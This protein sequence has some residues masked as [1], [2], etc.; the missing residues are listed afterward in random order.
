MKSTLAG[1]FVAS[2]LALLPFVTTSHLFYGP[3]SAKFFFIVLLVDILA[4]I[5]AYRLFRDKATIPHGRW[6]S[7]SLIVLLLVQIAASLLGVFP[8]RSLWSDIFWSSGTFFIVHIGV[9][10][11]LL[12]NLLSGRD[13]SLVRRAVIFSAG[14]FAV[15]SIT[16]VAGFGA[17]GN[18]LWINLGQ[19]GLTLG[20]ETYAGTYLLLA[21]V[22][23]LLEVVSMKGGRKLRIALIGS[24]V[25][26]ALS[27]LMVNLDLFLGRS[28]FDEIIANPAHL[29]GLARASSAA[30]FAVLVFMAGYALT[31]RLVP[32]PS[33]RVVAIAWGGILIIASC[34]GIA[35]LF[36]PGS[37]VQQAY[38]EESSAA[39]II[40]WE[41]G[42]KAFAE[43]PFLGWG[44]ENFDRALM[45]HFDSRLFLEENLAEIWFDR[46]HNVFID[47]LVGSGAIGL[48]S[49]CLLSGAYFFVVYRARRRS[50]IGDTEMALLI[51][52]VPA[53]ILQ[54]QTGFDTIASYTLLAV[55][56]GYVLW[57]ERELTP[58]TF[59]LKQAPRTIVVW[60]FVIG[61]STSAFLVF[62]E[63]SRQTALVETFRVR[64]FTEQQANMEHSLT[65]ISSFE[66]L[67]LSSA[68]F[69]NG[70]LALIA[71]ESTRE[72]RQAIL[73]MAQ[74]YEKYY[75]R[76]LSAQPHHYR[77]HINY[78][79]LLLIMTTLGEDRTDDAKAIIQAS[80]ALSPNNPL[81]YVLDAL[82]E[83]YKGNLVESKRLLAE[84]R[85][86]NPDITYTQEAETYFLKQYITF[87]NL[88]VLKLTNL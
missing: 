79:Y 13:W 2:A 23:G 34:L 19:T 10:A 55:V 33:S 35:L 8:E 41:A 72:R 77:A 73:L 87:P 27:P 68:S 7:W 14:V 9:G 45:E 64:S 78:A 17:S 31:L 84:A 67:R 24:L 15:L 75:Q 61:A 46:A 42:M 66:S 26:V 52:L 39:R 18:F 85:A 83:L 11:W 5:A 82:A 76:F 50:L 6:L 54:L 37:F 48:A 57:L 20:N 38:I 60:A 40:V 30:L 32:P 63:Y 56:G 28:L 86:I 21:F 4:L 74:E 59:S 3:V 71:E 12:A 47:T 36:T 80:Y 69:L 53:H 22:L 43:H 58:H 62:T 29:L 81:T 16:G 70:S 1:I 51:A 25:L 88:T 49:F 65:R 44:P